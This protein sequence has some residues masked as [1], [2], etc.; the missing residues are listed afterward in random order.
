[1]AV[2]ATKR[3]VLPRRRRTGASPTA[4]IAKRASVKLTKEERAAKKLADGDLMTSAS[5]S[6]FEDSLSGMS[7]GEGAVSA[8][9]AALAAGF[10]QAPLGAS[11]GGA[12]SHFKWR[13]KARGWRSSRGACVGEPRR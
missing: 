10:H 1:M 12:A 7:D 5:G 8:T 6:D 3:G 9:I 11:E 13:R 2:P 4:T